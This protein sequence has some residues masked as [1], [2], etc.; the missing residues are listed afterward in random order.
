MNL[1]YL[2]KEFYSLI[3]RRPFGDDCHDIDILQAISRQTSS[4]QMFLSNEQ[5][6]Q[7]NN[8][9]YLDREWAFLAHVANRVLSSTKYQTTTML[10]NYN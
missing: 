9:Q 3:S 10:L 8:A 4:A 5:H 2:I 7:N 6:L 1:V